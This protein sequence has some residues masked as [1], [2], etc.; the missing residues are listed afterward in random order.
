MPPLAFRVRAEVRLLPCLGSRLVLNHNPMNGS[1]AVK[2]KKRG[3]PATGRDP[4]VGVRFPPQTIREIDRVAAA[5][6]EKRSEAIRRLVE[7]ALKR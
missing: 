5:A 7:Q 3:R 1:I 4:I 2:Q 6:G